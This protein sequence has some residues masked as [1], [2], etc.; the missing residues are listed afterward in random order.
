MYLC[1]DPERQC[2]SVVFGE[3]EAYRQQANQN[4]IHGWL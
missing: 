4:E 2:G 1:G 3:I